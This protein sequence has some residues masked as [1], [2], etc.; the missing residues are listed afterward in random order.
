[1][2]GVALPIV[3]ILTL[4]LIRLRVF[5]QETAH[6]GTRIVLGALTIAAVVVFSFVMFHFIDR[7]QTGT[8]Q[9]VADL[10]RRQREG[11]GFYDVLLRISNQND[12]ADILA[13]VARHARDL[14]ASD[15]AVVCLS[16][17]TTQSVRLDWAPTGS[18]TLP[19]GV[20]ISPAADMT[21]A[22]HDDGA[23]CP[24]HSSSK[25]TESLRSPIQS[26]DK[27]LGELWIGRES[28]AHFTERDRQFLSTLA[29]LASI[30]VTSARIREGEWQS[31][32]LAERE[33][34]AR[35]MHDSLAQILGVTHLRLRALSLRD[36]TWDMQATA[37]EL[38]ELADICQEGYRD[39]REAILDL[40]ESSRTDRGLLDGLRAYLDK[41]SHQ[42]GISTSLEIT[43]DHDL[44]L[45]PRGEIQIIRVI[46]EALTNVRKHSGATSAV[47]RIT[48]TDGTATF[49]V[50]DDG[51]G[52]ELAAAP[53][54]RDAFGLH[55]MRQRMELIRGT[56]RIDSEPG[57][58]T[59]VI[60]E[61]PNI[62][63]PTP[64]LVEVD[65]A[66]N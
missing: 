40:R 2:I 43:P 61:I 49:V 65:G 52:F 47:V 51:R 62:P 21:H 11:H 8:A 13:A 44:V 64:N 56:L 55:S 45:P 24:I 15:D 60:A 33:R 28:G 50:E 26:R 17:T 32:I 5:E 19:D 46:Q 16:S 29:D 53:P 39:V 3:F 63:A 31:A 66:G 38:T 35:E 59:R 6:F 7:A 10:R 12:L 34:I 9:L 22:L 57:R 27:V 37:A 30:A 20:C 36:D 54:D 23:N 41:Y 18:A 14:L 48:E 25:F 58:G 42:C 4:E 1:M